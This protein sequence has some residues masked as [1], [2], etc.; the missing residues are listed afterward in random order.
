MHNRRKVLTLL[1]LV[2]LLLTLAVPAFAENTMETGSI[3]ID[4]AVSG[5]T[6][7]VYR[8]LDLADH[9]EPVNG[10]YTGVRYKVSQKWAEFFGKDGA[11]FSYIS[12]DKQ[13][14]VTWTTDKNKTAAGLAEAAGA[15]AKT[16]PIAADA[17]S[18]TAGESGQVCFQNL[19]LG[20]YLVCSNLVSTDAVCSLDTTRPNVIIKEKNS[21][22]NNIKEVQEDETKEWGDQNDADIGQTVNFRSTIQ[23]RDGNPKNYVF[24]D[25]M[26]EGLEFDPESL[27]ITRGQDTFTDA[28]YTLY[29]KGAEGVDDNSCTF[30]VHFKDG[31]LKPN[32]VIVLEYSATVTEEAVVG[33]ST[34]ESGNFNR[35][36]ITYGNDG[37][38][39]W[40]QTVTETWQLNILKYTWVENSTLPPVTEVDPDGTETLA[41]EQN[42]ETLAGAKFVLYKLGE[43]QLPTYLTANSIEST[44]GTYMVSGWTQESDDPEA[45]EKNKSSATTLVTPQ[46]GRISILGLDSG[47]YY[48]EEIAA[49]P[50]YTLLES[51]IAVKITNEG[52]VYRLD[53]SGQISG[54]A[55]KNETVGVENKRGEYLPETGG[56]GTTIFYVLGGGLALLAGVLLL[57][58]RK[59]KDDEA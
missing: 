42:Q 38:T 39:A 8:L 27:E 3:T 7:T 47:I 58:G 14:Y 19:T 51:P 33:S 21:A 54:S 40:D 15:Y 10:E 26:S 29:L 50:G 4:N 11:G 23:V 22:S 41:I 20:Y 5:A 13:G 30:E 9:N 35:S 6:Y 46:S 45:P 1:V 52:K 18:Q 48:L 44:A 31:V 56:I 32:D 36:K 34:N 59:A 24:H 53:A 17:D 55:L 2:A 57:T 16:K 49:P 28:Q 43:K 25:E 37:E 12:T